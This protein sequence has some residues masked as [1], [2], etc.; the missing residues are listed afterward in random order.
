MINFLKGFTDFFKTV[1]RELILIILAVSAFRLSGV[2]LQVADPTAGIF[3]MGL[4]QAIFFGLCIFSSGLF[5]VF[6]VVWISFPE[7][8]KILDEGLFNQTDRWKSI[9]TLSF[10][11]ALLLIYVLCCKICLS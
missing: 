3:D 8:D 9:L 10:V 2:A 11:S 4:I 6:L 5:I 7:I 1:K